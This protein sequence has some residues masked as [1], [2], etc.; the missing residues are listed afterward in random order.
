MILVALGAN[1]PSRF[2]TPAQTL[3]AALKAMAERGVWPVQI[4]RIW[5]TAPVPF[6]ETQPWFHNAVAMVETDLEPM[7]LL[8]TLLAIE[9][10]FG[11]VRTVR[12]VRNAPRLLDLDLIVYHE[13]VIREAETLIVPHPRMGDR[14]FVLMPMCDLLDDWVHPQSGKTLEQLV[15]LLPDDQKAEPMENGWDG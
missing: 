8:N 6:D 10:D 5:K 9:E 11:R 4:S 12:T 7:A 3:Y 2:G 14:A 1:L 13:K 15:A